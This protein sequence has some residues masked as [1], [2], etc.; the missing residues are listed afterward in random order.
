MYLL[1]L[2]GQKAYNIRM[3]L[4]IDGLSKRFDVSIRLD[5]PEPVYCFVQTWYDNKYY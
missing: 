4:D 1:K 5:V 3:H 2:L